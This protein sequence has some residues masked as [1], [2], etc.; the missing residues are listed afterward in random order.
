MVRP[1][2][3]RLPLQERLYA[4]LPANAAS[5]QWWEMGVGVGRGGGVPCVFL[6]EAGAVDLAAVR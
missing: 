5:L 4:S 1:F 2:A 6:A 3:T